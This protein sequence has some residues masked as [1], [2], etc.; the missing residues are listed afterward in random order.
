VVFPERKN[1]AAARLRQPEQAAA[2]LL[3]G[4]GQ[5][6]VTAKAEVRAG[7]EFYFEEGELLLPPKFDPTPEENKR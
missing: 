3:I 4:G 1:V 6:S 5:G 7:V 2:T